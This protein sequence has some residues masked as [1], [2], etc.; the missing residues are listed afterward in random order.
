[1]IHYD[2]D[3]LPEITEYTV[4]YSQKNANNIAVK[5]TYDSLYLDMRFMLS[6]ILDDTGTM[7]WMD[8]EDNRGIKALQLINQILSRS[9][10]SYVDIWAMGNDLKN[11]LA[12]GPSR[13]ASTE[14]PAALGTLLSSGKNS[15]IWT[16]AILASGGINEVGVNAVLER[17]NAYS[18]AIDYM[19]SMYRIDNDVLL[20]M[21]PTYLGIQI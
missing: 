21:D 15:E 14:I 6:F 11:L 12:Y 18:W 8:K 13:D 5:N 7:K 4:K 3:N 17:E 20:E 1:M 16:G 19:N 10:W 2:A 9:R